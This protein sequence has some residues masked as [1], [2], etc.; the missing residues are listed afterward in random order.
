[1]TSPMANDRQPPTFRKN[2][3]A[4]EDQNAIKL[5]SSEIDKFKQRNFTIVII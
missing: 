3:Q 2:P 4:E 1:M 5:Y